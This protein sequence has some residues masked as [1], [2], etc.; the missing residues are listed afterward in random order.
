[1]KNLFLI[2]FLTA[3][4]VSF[5]Q[6]KTPSKTNV[7]T[8]GCEVVE[9]AFVNKGGKTSEFKE[10]YLRCSIQDYFIK[11]CESKVPLK[12]M[13][14]YINQGL[15]VTYEVREGEWDICEGDPEMQSRIGTYAIVLKIKKSKPRKPIAKSGVRFL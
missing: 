5:S 13:K 12:K 4:A 10:L 6:T 3:S 14:K 2:I 11:F 15:T 1:M 9:K 7:T 8:T